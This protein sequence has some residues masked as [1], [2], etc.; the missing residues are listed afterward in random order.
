M[1][2]KQV[3]PEDCQ[4]IRRGKHG[5]PCY[6]EMISVGVEC[7]NLC[8]TELADASE[9]EVWGMLNDGTCFLDERNPIG[10]RAYYEAR[11][12]G[13]SIALPEP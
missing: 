6:R 3:N 10:M 2:Y 8:P 1:E 13:Y 9:R 7:G 11:F 5:T 4:Q 12:V